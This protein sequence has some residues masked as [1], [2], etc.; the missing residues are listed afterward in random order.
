MFR[1]S[2]ISLRFFSFL[3]LFNTVAINAQLLKDNATLDQIKQAVTNVYNFHF[4]DSREICR[5]IAQRYPGHPVNFL[6]NGLI[7]YWEDYPLLPT[8]PDHGLF[9]ENLR[10]CIELC[11]KENNT[12][13][14]DEFLITNLCARG[15]LLLFYS[16]NNLNKEVIPLAISTYKYIRLAFENTSVLPDFYFFTGL[17]NYYT[18][19][20]PEAHPVYQSVALLFPKGNKAAGLKDLEN[21]ARNSYVLN[22]ESSSFLSN[23]YINFEINYPQAAI[24]TKSLH[25]KYPNNT[26]YFAGYIKSLLLIRN[27]DEAEKQIILAQTFS[28]NK[29]F[30]GQLTIL[31]AILQEKKYRKYK[32]AEAFY[33]QGLKQ[34]S[35][36]GNYSKEFSAYAYFGLSRIRGK[37]N[38]A[39]GKKYFLEKANDV[40]VYKKVNFNE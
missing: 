18:E 15:F 38:D 20:Y 7:L 19:A 13:T 6:L 30:A 36:Y 17:Y 28:E 10:H 11:E 26:Q 23:I 24:H 25:D 34:I 14:K 37:F 9:E 16:D 22:A 33:N 1:R 8:S 21:C 5:K 29:Y 39:T 27:Y 31:H 2:K 32:S 4:N 12:S 35:D 3:L 40:A